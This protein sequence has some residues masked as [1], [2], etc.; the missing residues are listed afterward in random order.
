MR[1]SGRWLELLRGE[2]I[3]PLCEPVI[4]KRGG[5]HPKQ[6]IQ[7]HFH[8][9]PSIRITQPPLFCNRYF[10]TFCENCYKYQFFVDNIW[11]AQRKISHILLSTYT[12]IYYTRARKFAQNGKAR[13]R[14][15]KEQRLP[16]A[17]VNK[18]IVLRGK[19]IRTNTPN[20]ISSSRIKNS[21][22]QLLIPNS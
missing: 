8:R 14:V 19:T 9:A 17:Y 11:Y 18:E 13:Y 5:K 1:R 15:R 12:Y 3:S 2:S 21:T 4:Q 7:S 10:T 20:T 16:L 22:P 6:S